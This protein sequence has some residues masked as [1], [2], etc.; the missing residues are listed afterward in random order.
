MLST[1]E[2]LPYYSFG[3]GIYANTLVPFV[4]DPHGL[5]NVGITQSILLGTY[6]IAFEGDALS[7]PVTLEYHFNI[8]L[9]RLLH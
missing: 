9:L 8:V 5:T 1:E 7:I 2:K 4:N 3:F 6:I